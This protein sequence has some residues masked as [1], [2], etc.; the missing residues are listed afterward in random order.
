MRFLILITAFLFSGLALAQTPPVE[1]MDWITS[2][3]LFL[4]QVPTAGPYVAKAFEIVAIV[5]SIS[6]GLSAGLL[7]ILRVPQVIALWADAQ[8]VA[9]EIENFEKKVLP[10][11]AYLS[12]FNVQKK[13]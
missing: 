9:R 4:K 8:N 6:T 10:W 2:V 11:L 12:M 13:K 5:A 3:I 7:I 1:G